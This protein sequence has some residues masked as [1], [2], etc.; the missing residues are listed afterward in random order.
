[1]DD[2]FT[3]RAARAFVYWLP[4]VL[5]ANVVGTTVGLRVP[6]RA[7]R[8]LTLGLAFSAGALTAITA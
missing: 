1:M 8:F 2:P 4:G 3:G 5:L 6:D 7:F